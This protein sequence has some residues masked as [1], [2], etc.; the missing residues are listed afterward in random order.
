MTVLITTATG[1]VGKHIARNMIAAGDKPRLFVRDP[2]AIKAVFPE[3]EYEIAQGELYDADSIRSAMQ[4][5]EAV[6]FPGLD[7]LA[8]DLSYADHIINAAVGAGTQ[9]I[10]FLSAFMA[11]SSSDSAFVKMMGVLEDKVKA[12]GLDYTILG[13]EWFM[14]NFFGYVADGVLAMPFGQGQNSF[15]AT[16]DV[17]EVAAEALRGGHENRSYIITG[18]QTMDHNGVTAVIAE[19]VGKPCVY[20]ALNE[21]QFRE[22]TA[23]LG[24]EQWQ[25][26]LY[27]DITSFMRE[28]QI[29]G[30][31]DD[32]EKILG[33]K[34]MSLSEFVG[35]YQQEFTALCG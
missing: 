14:D 2:E 8:A 22:K 3:G 32:V 34:P 35:Q 28:G 24:W 7:S 23:A 25:T 15:V 6:F 12:S 18:P 33:R 11:D 16:D 1:K 21:E 20:K 31:S 17:G 26:E 13:A 19:A 4:G 27:I 5:V 10:V 30:T 29:A 9:R